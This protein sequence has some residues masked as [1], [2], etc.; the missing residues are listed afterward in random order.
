MRMSDVHTFLQRIL[1]DTGYEDK[2]YEIGM[3]LVA[4]WIEC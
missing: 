2:S 1:L 3:A 4:L